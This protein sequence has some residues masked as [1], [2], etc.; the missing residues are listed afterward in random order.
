[1]PL[2]VYTDQRGPKNR[3]TLATVI[4]KLYSFDLLWTHRGRVVDVI[5]LQHVQSGVVTPH[6]TT[7]LV[8]RD[9]TLHFEM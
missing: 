6:H 8:V 5:C 2:P 1:L 7:F 4:L 9:T 3:T